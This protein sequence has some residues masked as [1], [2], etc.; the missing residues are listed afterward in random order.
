M[1]YP[2]YESG[3]I[4]TF[5]AGNNVITLY[6]AQTSGSLSFDISYSGASSLFMSLGCVFA[7]ALAVF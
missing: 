6:N 2:N 3:D 1:E 5:E 7:A 4:L